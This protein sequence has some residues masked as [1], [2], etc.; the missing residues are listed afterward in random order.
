ME[1]RCAITVL[2]EA[3]AITLDPDRQPR[4][5]NSLMARRHEY[6]PIRIAAR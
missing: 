6:L 3:T 1:A 5:V 4:W 2:L